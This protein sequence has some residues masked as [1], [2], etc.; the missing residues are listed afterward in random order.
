MYSYICGI[1]KEIESDAI[2]VEQ[3]G[4]GYRINS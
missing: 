4:I 2:T 3:S 1:I